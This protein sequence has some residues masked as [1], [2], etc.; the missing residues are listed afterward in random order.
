MMGNSDDDD[1][2]AFTQCELIKGEE[3]DVDLNLAVQQNT[4]QRSDNKE[5][6][7]GGEEDDADL[8]VAAGPSQTK[9]QKRMS[10]KKWNELTTHWSAQM[11]ETVPNFKFDELREEGKLEVGVSH[12]LP[13]DTTP[14]DF[15]SLLLPE[16]FWSDVAEQTNLYAQ[17]KKKREQ[18]TR[19]GNKQHQ[20]K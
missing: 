17:Q 18:Q 4:S 6:E 16:S 10:K 1:E 14:F 13:A 12:D 8:P 9:Q 19:T 2:E 20:L 15:F 5:S 7:S 3:S 11:K